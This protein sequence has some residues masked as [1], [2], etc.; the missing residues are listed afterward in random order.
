MPPH[1]NISTPTLE[2]T[3]PRKHHHHHHHRNSKHQDSKN[4]SR[5]MSDYSWGNIKG[6]Q[7][8]D[9]VMVSAQEPMKSVFEFDD[10]PLR[11][12]TNKVEVRNLE[13]GADENREKED[14]VQFVQ[15]PNSP[16]SNR[17]G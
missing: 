14:N 15:Y 12:E 11:E 13:Q 5:T 3:P 10:E 1:R 6:E 2:A 9:L 8:E 4:N 17:N 16:N 7:D